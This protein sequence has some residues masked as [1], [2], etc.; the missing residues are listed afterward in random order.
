MHE[1]IAGMDVL[2]LRFSH[3]PSEVFGYRFGP[4][5]YLT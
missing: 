3:G 5:A 4:I 1:R 2:P